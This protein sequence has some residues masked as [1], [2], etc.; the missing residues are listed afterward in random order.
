[1]GGG[2]GWS[3]GDVSPP[4]GPGQ[5]PGGGRG[6]K[7]PGIICVFG[8]ENAPEELTQ[9]CGSRMQSVHT[10]FQK[11]SSSCQNLFLERCGS[12]LTWSIAPS[13]PVP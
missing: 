13:S 3:G 11:G 10:P 1:M 8:F 12:R 5:N 7:A 9:L 4:V 6:G 2:G